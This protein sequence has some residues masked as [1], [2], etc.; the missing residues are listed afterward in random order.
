MAPIL[1][2]NGLPSGVSFQVA[3]PPSSQGW[4]QKSFGS[5]PCRGLKEES[6]R[7]NRCF[8]SASRPACKQKLWLEWCKASARETRQ[9]TVYTYITQYT[10]KIHSLNPHVMQW[11]LKMWSQWHWHLATSV[12]HWACNTDRSALAAVSLLFSLGGLP[13]FSDLVRQDLLCHH[14]GF[15]NILA[16]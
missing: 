15:G 14:V 10:T 1:L 16:T 8:T 5:S 12:P 2:M 11:S 9:G 6:W 7:R 3:C 4:H 13:A